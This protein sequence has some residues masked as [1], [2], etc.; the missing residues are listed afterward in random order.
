MILSTADLKRF[1]SYVLRRGEDECWPWTGCSYPDGYGAFWL[2]DQNK[3]AHRVAATWCS[4]PGCF[5]HFHPRDGEAR[6]SLPDGWGLVRDDGE[7]IRAVAAGERSP[8]LLPVCSEHAEH[9][10]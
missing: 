7:K 9:A 1:E 5:E 10:K 8:R 4:R 3:R 2:V 6:G